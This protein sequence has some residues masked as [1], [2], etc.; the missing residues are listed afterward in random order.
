[1]QQRTSAGDIVRCIFF[2]RM[3][4][5][6]VNVSFLCDSQA[7]RKNI[8]DLYNPNFTI[9]DSFLLFLFVCLILYVP[10]NNLSVTST[11]LPGLNQF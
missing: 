9:L 3:G 7:S 2:P 1:M 11:G 5:K 6:L 8:S 10:V 4:F